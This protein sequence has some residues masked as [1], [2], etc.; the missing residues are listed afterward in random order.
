MKVVQR[1]RHDDGRTLELCEEGSDNFSLWQIYP[2]KDQVENEL[3]REDAESKIEELGYSIDAQK[4][5]PPCPNC[6]EP[7]N[8]SL[9]TGLYFCEA[10]Q[11]AY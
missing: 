2:I 9:E 8:M 4:F 10:C 7:C 3:S 11:T 1:Y 5:A 6:H